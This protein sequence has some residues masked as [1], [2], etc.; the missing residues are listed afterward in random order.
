MSSLRVAVVPCDGIGVEVIAEAVKVADALSDV[1]GGALF[2]LRFPSV[3]TAIALRDG[4]DET[5]ERIRVATQDVDSVLFGAIGRPDLGKD[6]RAGE[7]ARKLLLQTF[8]GNASAVVDS[9]VNPGFGNNVNV[10]PAQVIHES[11]ALSDYQLTRIS[12]RKHNFRNV[13]QVGSAESSIRE[14]VIDWAGA[15]AVEV[16][17]IHL[18]AEYK[19]AAINACRDAVKAFRHSQNKPQVIIVHKANVHELSQGTFIKDLVQELN[20]EFGARVEVIQQHTDIALTNL[21]KYTDKF[22]EFIVA[23]PCDAYVISDALTALNQNQ[24]RVRVYPGWDVKIYRENLED[25]YISIGESYEFRSGGVQIGRHTDFL[26]RENIKAALAEVIRM[27]LSTLHIILDSK[28][29]PLT[30]KLWNEVALEVVKGTG[31]KIKPIESSEFML[32]LV[33]DPCSLS[34]GVYASRNKFGDYKSDAAIAHSGGVGEAASFSFSSNDYTLGHGK[35]TL[36][37]PVAGSALDGN[38][39]R[40]VEQPNPDAAIASLEM[41]LVGHS[42]SAEANLSELQDLPHKGWSSLHPISEVLITT[43]WKFCC[44]TYYYLNL[45]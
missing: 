6:P 31:I 3:D 30:S 40:T 38:G 8:R 1:S 32:K 18:K 26:I 36:A 24:Q 37:E 9:R 11:Q 2:E 29:Y 19:Q 23:D 7:F 15:S 45:S 21:I 39:R 20:Q 35:P 22:P 14:A 44:K 43:S 28:N 13:Y 17:E 12:A 27:R 34:P 33:V 41:M 16:R 4:V 5:I 25:S 10:R 42:F